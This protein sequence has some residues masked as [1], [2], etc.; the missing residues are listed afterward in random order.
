M[1]TQLSVEPIKV[2]GAGPVKK[3]FLKK[4]LGLDEG[5]HVGVLKIDDVNAVMVFPYNIQGGMDSKIQ[6][7]M[8]AIHEIDVAALDDVTV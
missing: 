2:K 4:E 3:L 8:D 6:A 7:I 1:K 5:Q